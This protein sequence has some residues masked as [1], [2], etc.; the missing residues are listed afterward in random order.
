MG[1]APYVAKK[2]RACPPAPCPINRLCTKRGTARLD[3]L[4]VS[5]RDTAA[6]LI[7]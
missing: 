5:V 4:A 1:F 6:L 3:L 2:R 7:Y